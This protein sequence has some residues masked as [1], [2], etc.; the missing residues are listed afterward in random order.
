MRK[1]SAMI[2][3]ILLVSSLCYAQSIVV[4]TVEVDGAIQVICFTL[5]DANT[6]EYDGCCSTLATQDPNAYVQAHMAGWIDEIAAI[7]ASPDTPHWMDTGSD[8]A[9]FPYTFPE[10]I[11][12]VGLLYIKGPAGLVKSLEP[13]TYGQVLTADPNQASKM[14]WAAAGGG[15]GTPSDSVVAETSF[16][17]SQSAGTASTYSR[18]DHTHGTPVNPVTGH[19]ASY[20]HALLHANTN[21]PTADQKAA[22]AGTSGTPSAT[23]K[24]VTNDD[25][26]NTNARTPV[27]HN[28]AATEITSGSLD[29]DRLPALSTAKRGGVPATGAPSG[30]Y[31]RDDDTWQTVS[32]GSSPAGVL[33]DLQISVLQG[34]GNLAEAS[35]VQTWAGSDKT[36]QDVFTVEANTTY[37]VEGQ[38]I[39]N[40]GA[41]THTT[42]MA[43]ALGGGAT[44]ASVEYQVMLWAAAA[45][46]I[47]TAQSTVHVSGVASKVL[48]ATGA[49]VYT[50]I[51]FKGIFVVTAGGTI[52][53][54]IAFSANPTG[55]CLMKRGSWVSFSKIGADAFIEAGGWS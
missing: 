41:T 52:T 23:N 37:L 9:W 26:R 17:A 8:V 49:L 31:L 43:W 45:N 12:A 28:H 6:N 38:Y 47:A 7:A 51:Q 20:N 14:K 22:L 30:K 2:L 35:G 4:N 1:I 5:T 11:P 34:N 29:G 54:Q 40:T 15:S 16:G 42:A 53:P 32:G 55:T 27:A 25:S 39:I 36:S 50:N 21:D 44:V 24:Y 48:N 13:G 18:G 33:K 3:A 10:L 19:E 46:G